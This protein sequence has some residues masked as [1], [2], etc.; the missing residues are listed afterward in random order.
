MTKQPRFFYGWVIVAVAFTMMAVGYAL[1]NT[2][3]VFYPALVEDFGWARGSTALMFSINIIVYGITAPIA[4]GLADRFS[5]R[6]VF[7]IGICIMGGAI[8]MCSVATQQWQFFLLYGVGAAAGLS[9][10]GVT[11]L[12]TIMARW[13]VRRRA[14]AFGI[15]NMG[16]GFSLLASPIAQSLITGLGRDRAYFT[17]GLLAIAIS[18]P[19]VLIFMRRSPADKGT[20]PDGIAEPVS[21][22]DSPLQREV[23][24]QWT[25]TDWTLAKAMRTKTLWLMFVADFF[26]MGIAQQVVIAHSVYFFRDA[27]FSAQSAA[28]TFSFYGIGITIGYMFAYLSD[29]IGRERVFVPGCLLAALAT[30][31]LFVV[32]GPSFTWLGAVCMFL[33]GLGMGAGVTTFFATVA[34][35]FQGKNYGSIMGFVTFGFSLGGAFSPWFVGYLNDTTGSYDIALWMVIG[36]LIV[37]SVLVTLAAPRRLRPVP[38]VASRLAAPRK[39]GI[40]V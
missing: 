34:D 8:A 23:S 16:F 12:N 1:R 9:M 37:A 40:P 26:M 10:T 39:R 19:L 2:F 20:F 7:P 25:R 13:F 11:T 29:K 21:N 35:L 31:L 3:S 27:G 14:L 38:G 36:A 18:V 6:L 30:G 33:S 32:T 5:P 22:V 15:F 24:T 4:G 17:I 28:N